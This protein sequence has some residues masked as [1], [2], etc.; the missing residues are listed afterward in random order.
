MS[1]GYG[2]SVRSGSRGYVLGG[3]RVKSVWECVR[4]GGREGYGGTAT[5]LQVRSVGEKAS[6]QENEGR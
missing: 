1:S 2:R 5:Y 3:G 4:D 6:G